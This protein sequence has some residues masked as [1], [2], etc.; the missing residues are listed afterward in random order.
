VGP[1]T[2]RARVKLLICGTKKEK[3][4]RGGWGKTT[5]KQRKTQLQKAKKTRKKKWEYRNACRPG[6]KVKN[7]FITPTRKRKNGRKSARDP[8]RTEL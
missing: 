5:T 2:T 1:L 8:K 4:A 7:R 3:R 6:G